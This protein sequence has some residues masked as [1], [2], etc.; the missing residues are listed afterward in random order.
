M[1][2]DEKITAAREYAKEIGA[3]AKRGGIFNKYGTFLAHSWE[4]FYDSCYPKPEKKKRGRKARA[5]TIEGSLVQP[6]GPATTA[7]EALNL[8]ADISVW[9]CDVLFG[10]TTTVEVV[11]E[12]MESDLHPLMVRARNLTLGRD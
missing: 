6:V 1:I 7:T 11:K 12:L 3:H 5:V 2:T 9:Y 4:K 8:L 10:E